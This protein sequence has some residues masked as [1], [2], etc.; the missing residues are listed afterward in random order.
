MGNAFTFKSLIGTGLALGLGVTLTGCPSNDP[1]AKAGDKAGKGDPGTDKGVKEAGKDGDEAGKLPEK[2]LPL[3]PLHPV[4]KLRNEFLA[5][6]AFDPNVLMLS[7]APTTTFVE[8]P[9]IKNK[10]AVLETTLTPAFTEMMLDVG[11]PEKQP[12]RLRTYQEGAIEVGGENIGITGPTLYVDAREL[13]ADQQFVSLKIKLCNRL[14]STDCSVP[15]GVSDHGGHGANMN[16]PAHFQADF[17]NLHT[18][19]MHVSPSGVSDNVFVLLEPGQFFDYTIDMPKDHPAGT[20]WYHAH[21]HGATATQLG[22]GMAGALIVAGGLDDAEGI[23]GRT[24]HVFVFQQIPWDNCQPNNP[25]TPYVPTSPG[26]NTYKCDGTIGPGFVNWDQV[27]EGWAK[28]YTRHTLVNGQTKPKLTMQPGEVQRWRFLHAGIQQNLQLH[29]CAKGDNTC[30][31]T[32]VPLNRI[33]IDG[34]AT[35]KIQPMNEVLMAPGY[36]VDVLIQAPACDQ[37][38]C[39]YQ[40]IDRGSTPSDSLL[41]RNEQGQVLAVIEVSGAALDQQLPTDLSAYL[42]Y[43]DVQPDEIDNEQIV[44]YAPS[45][46]TLCDACTANPDDKAACTGCNNFKACAANSSDVDACNGTLYNINGQPFDPSVVRELTLDTASKWTLS[47][48]TWGPHPFH[49]HVNPFQ[50]TDVK[51][52]GTQ[53]PLVDLALDKLLWRDVLLVQKGCTYTVLSRYEDFTGKFVQH[54]HILN[55]E[56]QGMMEAVNIN[57]ATTIPPVEPTAPP[58]P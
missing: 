50:L 43:K 48:A 44:V 30:A 3:T 10:G 7:E 47:A 1:N 5:A 52:D 33:A 21:N 24:D 57:P 11:V 14:N 19:G 4:L 56:D 37:P 12:V 41:E 28:F 22:N 55:H 51:C 31:T 15:G 23:K 54:C 46:T 49:I 32:G 8:P 25:A 35:G 6:A 34:I 39:E 36:R 20:H 29:L 18:H 58:S 27:T 13:S 17:T 53:N 26:A 45:Q 42:P 9:V 16:N 38:T 2:I 40:L